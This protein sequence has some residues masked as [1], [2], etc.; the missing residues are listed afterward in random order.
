[1]SFL[2]D[3]NVLVYAANKNSH[4]HSPCKSLVEKSFSEKSDNWCISWVNIFEFLRVMTHPK[5]LE[6]PLQLKEAEKNI[7][8]ILS[9]S[10][11]RILEPDPEFFSLFKE[12]SEEAGVIKGNLIHDTHIAALMKQEGVRRIYTLDT[13]FRLFPFIKAINPIVTS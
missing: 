9:L 8:S 1:V 6:N 4:H 13:H 5:Y 11:V 10:H 2:I 12:I 3:T 7:D